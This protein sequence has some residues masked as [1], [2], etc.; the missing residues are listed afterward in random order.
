MSAIRD[1]QSHLCA[2]FFEPD[3]SGVA[4]GV[5]ANVRETFLDDAKECRFDVL[6]KPADILDTAGI[7][8]DAGALR[9]PS[10]EPL[11]CAD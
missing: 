3:G 7:N 2:Y 11:K 9:K 10:D 5:A 8:I 4:P 1:L 6:W